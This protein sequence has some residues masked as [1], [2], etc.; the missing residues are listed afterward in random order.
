[1]TKQEAPGYQNVVKDPM[2]LDRIRQKGK[3]Q[4]YRSIDA[5]MADVQLMKDNCILFNDKPGYPPSM[6]SQKAI[7]LEQIARDLIE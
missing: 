4:E 1:M 7:E 6:Y 5:V 3:R 2:W